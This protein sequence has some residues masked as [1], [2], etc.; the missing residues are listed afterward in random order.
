MGVLAWR[1]FGLDV[2]VRISIVKMGIDIAYFWQESATV[3]QKSTYPSAECEASYS[4]K[5][6]AAHA[7]FIDMS[8]E[9]GTTYSTS[10]ATVPTSQVSCKHPR[11]IQHTLSNSRYHQA[12]QPNRISR[13]SQ[14]P[15]I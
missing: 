2:L 7:V 6:S 4:S 13:V 8:S 15:R 10:P 3:R 14:I 5:V 11:R 9:I 1:V 12:H